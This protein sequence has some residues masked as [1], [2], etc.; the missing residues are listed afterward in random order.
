MANDRNA[1]L[2]MAMMAGDMYGPNPYSQ[3]P[4]GIQGTSYAGTPTDALGRPIQ[5]GPSTPGLTLNSAPAAAAAPQQSNI[6]QF[7]QGG[8]GQYTGGGQY[9]AG[10]MAGQN[11]PTSWQINPAYA[12]QQIQQQN[13]PQ[14]GAPQAAA[15]P[16]QDNSYQ[17]ALSLLAN[18]GPITMPGATVPQSQPITNQPSVLDAFLSNNKGGGTGAGNYSNQGFFDTLNKLRPQ[19]GAQQ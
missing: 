10:Q 1:A 8:G 19:A 18:P 5:A 3:F 16:T 14:A 4:N 15:P 13:A 6:P 2:N 11:A 9:Q 7:V 17:H 12:I